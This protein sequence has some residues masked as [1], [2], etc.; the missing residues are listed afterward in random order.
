MGPDAPRTV[1]Y[2]NATSEIGGGDLCLLRTVK[3]LD[4]ARYRAV[5]A[6]PSDGPLVGDFRAA[7]ADVRFVEMVKPKFRW[8]PVYWLRVWRSMKRTGCVLADLA[9][10]CGAAL[11][12]TNSLH[13]PYGSAAARRANLPHVWHVR[14]IPVRHG[15]FTRFQR[16]HALARA[17]RLVAMSDAVAQLF[18]RDGQVPTKVVRIY[19]DVEPHWFE[20]ES[21][22]AAIL[23]RWNLPADSELAA[24]TCRFDPWKGLDVV[25]RAA[26]RLALKH[27]RLRT[28]FVGG[29]ILGHESYPDE[30]ARLARELGVEDRVVFT[31]WL[32]PEEI[33]PL[34][35]SVDLVVHASRWPEP[36]G[37]VIAEAMAAGTHVVATA[38]GGPVEFVRP[39][40]TGRL[41]ESDDPKSLAREMDAAL[42]NPETSAH[43]VENARALARREF[44]LEEN[45]RKLMA[46][47]D[48][49]LEGR[50]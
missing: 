39:G 47:Y 13:V 2:V 10:E 50:A 8:S 7:D 24:I 15:W 40:Q 32:A 43:M 18:A 21:D 38:H 36:F 14:E 20:I 34:V 49:I 11:V 30:L 29:E 45:T 22:R 12:H 5:V 4:P 46:V 17:D 3:G 23:Q 35:A 6:L 26:A 1:L 48:E 16:R 33:P 44:S 25:M 28:L 19:G 42:S 9:R 37:L 41:A 31:G 27:P